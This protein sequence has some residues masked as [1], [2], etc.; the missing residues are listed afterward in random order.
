[1]KKKSG[2]RFV[3]MVFVAVA[4]FAST[5][6][7]AASKDLLKVAL[8]SDPVSIN[9]VEFRTT[10]SLPITFLTHQ[11]VMGSVDPKTNTRVLRLAESVEVMED[12]KDIKV[13]LRKGLKFHSGD[14]VTAHDVQFTVEQVQDP[15]NSHILA[16]NFDEIDEIEVLDDRTLIYRF[17]EPFAPWPEVMWTGI[18]SKKQYE[19]VGRKAF[20]KR[21][22]GAG[23][24]R[25]VERKIDEHIILEAV[26]NHP[27]FRA[28]FKRL[29]IF[30]VS[31]STTRL[32]MLE[33]GELDIITHI[34]PD[35]A[36]RLQ[37]NP[38]LKIKKTSNWPSLYFLAIRPSLYPVIKDINVRMAMS[39]AIN[40]Q[41]LVDRVLFKEGYPL[42]MWANKNE[43]GFDPTYKIEYDPGKARR[44]LK[45]S[46]YKPG[47]PITLTYTNMIPKAAF[48]ASVIQHYLKNIGMT[49]K[50]QQLEWGVWVTYAINRD[51]RG[52]HM[53]L[54]Q[55]T[56]PFDPHP[57]LSLSFLSGG[58][59][60]HYFD[61]PNKLELDKLV[62][63]QSREMNPTK[64][65]G[66]FKKI[67]RINNTDPG[68]IPLYG[69][70]MIYGMNRHVDFTWMPGTLEALGLEK[71]KILK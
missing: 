4:C 70:N 31:D 16:E 20:R 51:K 13:T 27:D 3:A 43:L 65:L 38:R 26:E 7:W 52:G 14:P 21:P 36:E 34:Q 69:L 12:P 66:I 56:V 42:Y 18:V 17:Y 71:V 59:F 39:Y 15:V 25:L 49:V 62:F 30:V 37:R 9:P 64:R 28:E 50:L 5:A 32:A 35:Q 54:S 68:N 10:V 8:N 29:K 2:F 63:A 23:V 53:M 60:C 61:R 6:V 33:T 40:R 67:H 46:S 22:V 55:F 19:R 47:T 45:K 48:V 44:L 1:M 24:F 11:G 57:R 58:N 41:E